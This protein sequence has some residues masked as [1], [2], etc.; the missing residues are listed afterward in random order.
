MHQ[1]RL[2]WL[3]KLAKLV[4]LLIDLPS[5]QDYEQYPLKY[6]MNIINLITHAAI[7]MLHTVMQYNIH[8]IWKANHR[9]SCRFIEL[10]TGRLASFTYETGD[11]GYLS[12]YVALL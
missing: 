1:V 4:H 11:L 3:V 6:G 9:S 12:G 2:P 7:V 8:L 10:C 5:L